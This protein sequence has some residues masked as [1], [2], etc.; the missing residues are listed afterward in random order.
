MI[1]L[2]ALPILFIISMIKMNIHIVYQHEG[3]IDR[4]YFSIY[5]QILKFNLPFIRIDSDKKE[6]GLSL[7][8]E[9]AFRK[10]KTKKRRQK[11]RDTKKTQVS[12]TQIQRYI[13]KIKFMSDTYK[14]IFHGLK[15]YIQDKIIC[16]SFVLKVHFGLGDAALTGIATGVIWAFIYNGF[17]ILS[18]IVV[19]KEREINVWPDFNEKRSDI[20]FD[21]IFAMRIAHII[22]VFVL[23][24]FLLL[25]VLCG[26][27]FVLN[28]SKKI[29]SMI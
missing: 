3:E 17:S 18:R 13:D 8:F 10:K 14:H 22:I 11:K 16:P 7:W 25:K 21:S 1:Y 28:T 4:F 5:T 2:L 12:F 23:S 15:R 27:I 26:K 20:C 24:T 9:K 6:K 19:V 29:S